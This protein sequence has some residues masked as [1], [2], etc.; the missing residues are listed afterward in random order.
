[1]ACRDEVIAE[2]LLQN[3]HA[4]GEQRAAGTRYARPNMHIRLDVIDL[5]GAYAPEPMLHTDGRKLGRST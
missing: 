4:K 1:M 3:L 5:G 2:R